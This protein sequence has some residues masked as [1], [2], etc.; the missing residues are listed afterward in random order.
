MWQV[1]ITENSWSVV[2]RFF[3]SEQRQASEE[4]YAIAT[5]DTARVLALLNMDRKGD[6]DSLLQ[7]I[8]ECFEH[9]VMAKQ[10]Q[11]GAKSLQQYKDVVLKTKPLWRLAGASFSSNSNMVDIFMS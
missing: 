11:Q 1:N 9:V 3:D 7:Y 2:L 4:S 8:D 10:R 6:L 5:R